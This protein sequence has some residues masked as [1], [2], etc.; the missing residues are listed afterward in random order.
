MSPIYLT[1]VLNS[2]MVMN[3]ELEGSG[4]GDGLNWG[5]IPMHGLEDR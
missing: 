5:T 2:N 3:N 4:S 1:A